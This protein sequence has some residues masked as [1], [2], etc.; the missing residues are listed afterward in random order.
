FAREL[1]MWWGE[2]MTSLREHVSSR[3]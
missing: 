1:G 2:L 3:P